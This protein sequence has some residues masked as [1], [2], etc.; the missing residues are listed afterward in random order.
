MAEAAA[1][2]AKTAKGSAEVAQRSNA[3]SAIARRV[4][5]MVDGK[6]SVRELTPLAP[7]G[8]IDTVLAEL[9][10]LG[11]IE[12]VG[13]VAASAGPTLAPPREGGSER[14][15]LSLEEAKRRAARGLIERLGPEADGMAARIEAC[16]SAEELAEALRRAERLL[17][18]AIGAA[19]AESYLRE[20]RG[21]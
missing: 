21:R 14:L 2:F 11:L 9:Q 19:A 15:L 17:A 1:V 4:L 5:I 6:R 8:Q 3:I 7:P 13:A 12:A 18:G 10:Q 20:L 16:R